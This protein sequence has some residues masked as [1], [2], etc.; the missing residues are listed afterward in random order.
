LV[1][2]RKL[3]ALGWTVLDTTGSSR[4]G[5]MFSRG[6]ATK[7]QGRLHITRRSANIIPA[8]SAKEQRRV[9]QNEQQWMRGKRAGRTD[10]LQR[11]KYVPRLSK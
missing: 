10:N 6:V 7:H 11:A 9:I 3:D 4:H 8:V 2:N 1:F 5:R